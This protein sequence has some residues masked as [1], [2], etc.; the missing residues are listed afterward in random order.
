MYIVYETYIGAS[1]VMFFHHYHLFMTNVTDIAMENHG[2]S[3]PWREVLVAGQIH[4]F[5]HGSQEIP[6]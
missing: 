2:I 3:I 5:G 1:L 6:A 4:H